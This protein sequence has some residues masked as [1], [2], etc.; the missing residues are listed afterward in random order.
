MDNNTK[1]CKKCQKE[2]TFDN[3]Y[4]SPKGALGLQS[5]CIP[6]HKEK[7]YEWIKNNPEKYKAINKKNGSKWA[8][9]NPEKNREKVNQWAKDNPEK[10]SNKYHKR[11]ATLNKNESFYV[12]D[13]F[14]KNL[15]KSNCINCN[16]SENIEAD[17]IIPISRGGIHG[18]S[19][20]QPLC[21][22]CNTSKG[23]KTMTEW[24]LG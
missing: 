3:F 13:D 7:T 10:V 15:Y 11:K 16:N 24:L 12:S 9:N 20:L 4:K 14:M 2:K 8:K 19:N 5:Y 22:S 21:K 18:E 6:C 1:T 23:S 17:H